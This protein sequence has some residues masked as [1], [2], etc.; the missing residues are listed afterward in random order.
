[1][2]RRAYCRCTRVRNY[3]YD[4]AAKKLGCARRWLEDNISRL[5]RQKYGANPVFCECELALIRDMFTILPE[6]V[7]EYIAT[8]TAE[9]EPGEAGK[10]TA[11][12]ERTSPL[13]L[14]RPAQPRRK[15]A[16]R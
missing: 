14:I 1:M 10:P 4:Q 13:A 9:L 6:P 16:S 11:I 8:A 15:T 5:P 7:A 3:G 12:P 2:N